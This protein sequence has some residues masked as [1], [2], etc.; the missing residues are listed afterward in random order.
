MKPFVEHRQFHVDRALRHVGGHSHGEPIAPGLAVTLN[1]HPDMLASGI[2]V[3]ELLARDGAYRSQFETRTSNG[4]L[5]VYRGGER[6]AW[7]SRIFGGAY[8]DADP[9]LRPKYGALNHRHDPVGG[10]PRFGSCHLRLNA[11]VVARASFCYP[12][13]HLDP[14]AF[15]VAERMALIPFADA[16][17]SKVDPL[18]DYIEAHIHGRLVI[19][20]DI[21]AIVLDPCYRGT[22]VERAA[23]DL[24]CPVEWHGGFRLSAGRLGDCEQYRNTIAAKA[25]AAMSRDGFVTPLE[26][27]AA[28]LAEVDHQTLN[29]V[30]HCI[31]RFGRK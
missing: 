18:D 2:P 17:R 13:S 6:W 25:V 19:A 28:R 9:T 1:F 7:E 20:H 10:S 21:E 8:D 5:T 12:D 26:I 27:A 31:A 16:N 3:I 14:N 30:W 22:G 29:W 24:G 23:R 11:A 15:G 4:G